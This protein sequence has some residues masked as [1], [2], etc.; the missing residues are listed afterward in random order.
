MGFFK[1]LGTAVKKGMKQV[2]LKNVVKLGTPLLGAIP[3]AGGL[4]Q[5][6]VS[7]ISEAHEMKKQAKKLEAEGKQAEALAMQQQAEYLATQSGASVGQQVGGQLNAFAKGAANELKA[8]IGTT[9]N[10]VVGQAGATVVDLTIKEWFQKH[11]LKLVI[12]LTALSGVYLVLRKQGNKLYR[13][14]ASSSLKAKYASSK[15]WQR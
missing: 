12:A 15:Y 4:A 6:L 9:T 8:Q 7:N 5:S 1:K 13:N 14:G 2:S 11:W 10:Q 3:I